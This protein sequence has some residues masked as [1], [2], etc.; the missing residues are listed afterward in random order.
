MAKQE[1]KN[2]YEKPAVTPIGNSGGELSEVDLDAV[3]GGGENPAPYPACMTGQG[4]SSECYQGFAG[5]T[6]H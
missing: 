2:G 1:K 4:A 6:S 5:P 3:T